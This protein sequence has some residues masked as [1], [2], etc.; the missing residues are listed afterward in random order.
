MNIED[1]KAEL[2]KLAPE[3]EAAWNEYKRLQAT[4]VPA[5]QIWY[6]LHKKCDQLRSAIELLE[7]KRR[8]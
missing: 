1:I 7:P 6:S 4:V 3:T 2:A 5:Q 8:A